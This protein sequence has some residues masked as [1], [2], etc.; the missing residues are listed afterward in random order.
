MKAVVLL[1]GGMDSTTVL[2]QAAAKAYEIFALTMQYGQRHEAELQAARKIAQTFHVAKHLVFPIP[3]D[4]FGGSA[5][6]DSTIPV[7]LERQAG[8]IPSTYV[9]ARNTIF[10]TLALAWAEVIRAR[11]VFIGANDVDYSGYPDCR[12]EFF[13]KF[14]ELAQY[15]TRAG[16]EGDRFRIHAPLIGMRKAEII[17]TGVKLGVDY[18]MTVSCYQADAEGR[19]CG[20]C[21]ACRLRRQGFRDAG[22]DDPTRYRQG[23]IRTDPAAK[24]PTP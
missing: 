5:L 17:Q 21:D 4:M 10:L 22:V 8:R 24:G 16:V 19:A 12:S 6:T 7:P 14:S 1:S 3:L 11:D 15:A 9:P 20:Q 2:A 23:R 18:A 13:S